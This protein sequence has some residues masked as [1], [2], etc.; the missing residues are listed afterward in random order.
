[1]TTRPVRSRS[2]AL[3]PW[4]IAMKS[5]S[6]THAAMFFVCT[7]FAVS[8]CHEIGSPSM[9]SPARTAG[10]PAAQGQ[11]TLYIGDAFSEAEKVLAAL[12]ASEPMP[13]GY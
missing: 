13:N 12:P 6:A 9:A 5:I 2:L 10:D 11:A 3:Q 8:A 7:A 1:M 4:E